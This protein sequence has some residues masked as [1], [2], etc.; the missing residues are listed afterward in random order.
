MYQDNGTYYDTNNKQ[1]Q[2]PML[3]QRDI[4]LSQHSSLVNT[5]ANYPSM[6]TENKNV[7]FGL[8]HG[9]AFKVPYPIINKKRK[10]QFYGS[11]YSENE[12]TYTPISS[13]T[14]IYQSAMTF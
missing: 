14:F 13:Y 2:Q 7:M 1:Q 12:I 3:A 6:S 11:F 8:T 4:T 9:E 5:T 10:K